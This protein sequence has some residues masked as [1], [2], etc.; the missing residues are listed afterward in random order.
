MRRIRPVALALLALLLTAPLCPGMATEVPEEAEAMMADARELMRNGDGASA[1]S[2]VR[3]AAEIAPNWPAPHAS[4]GVLYQLHGAQDLARDRYM[5]VQLIS[6][7]REGQEDNRATREIAQGEALMVYLAN[8]ERTE[9]GLPL[10]RPHADLAIVARRHSREMRDLGFFSHVS[11]TAHNRRPSD[12]F[13]TVFGQRPT[14]I[15]ENLARM[16][17]TS[18]WSFTHDNLR[19]SH[20]RLMKSTKHR[21]VILWDKPDHVGVGIAVNQRGD[22]WITEDFAVLTRR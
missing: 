13:L 3:R 10:L 17:S 12:R 2:K 1:L 11:P 20:E 14:A 4:L 7:L 16:A 5:Q 19:D 15:G 18:H 9:R 21:K 22:Y 8:V 6:M